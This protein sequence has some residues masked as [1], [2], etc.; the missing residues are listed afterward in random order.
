[1]T[2]YADLS[3]RQRDTSRHPKTV[4]FVVR[5]E[6]AHRFPSETKSEH[7]SSFVAFVGAA[8]IEKAAH[9]QIDFALCLHRVHFR[10]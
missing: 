3:S 9:H 6:D 5:K 7:V 1:M 10:F 8:D 4:L 2:K